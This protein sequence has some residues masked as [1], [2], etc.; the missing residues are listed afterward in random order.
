[1]N[2]KSKTEKFVSERAYI[3]ENQIFE[4]VQNRSL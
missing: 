1:M 2:T 4:K 3:F